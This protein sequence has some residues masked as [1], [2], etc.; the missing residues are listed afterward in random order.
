MAVLVELRFIGHTRQAGL[1]DLPDFSDPSLVLL[2][3]ESQGI[4]AGG[5]RGP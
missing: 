5:T 3:T 2:L 4:R 1:G